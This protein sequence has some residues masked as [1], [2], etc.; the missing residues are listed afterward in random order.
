M[1]VNTVQAIINGQ[2]YNLT[3]NSSTGKYEATITAPATSSYPLDG[4]YY[5]VKVT[6]TDTAGN[7]VEA[8]DTDETLGS[9]LRLRV[10]EKVAPISDITSPTAGQLTSNNKPEITW[11]VTDNDSGVNPDSIKLSIDNV[12]VSGTI[13]KQAISGGY[14]CSYTP[15]TAL[16]DGEHTVS[17]AASDND[18]NAAAA[19]SVTFEVLATAPNLS[20]TS[21]ANNSYH[22]AASV[23]FAGTT[24][25]ATMTVQVGSGTAQNVPISGG[26]FS[27]T[28]TLTTEGANTVTFRAVSESGVETVVTRT[29]YLDTKAP[30][31]QSVSIT[32]NPVDA[33]ATYIISVEVAD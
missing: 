30:V 31:I 13:T 18:G 19:E 9:S 17:V 6:A 12:Q 8:D 33:G 22:K 24:N 5:P 15:D 4:H 21:P 29:L 28:L 10:Q 2:T 11:T 3:R 20:V 7:L 32:P 25:G 26:S 23:P 16:D 27:G 14:S 1:A